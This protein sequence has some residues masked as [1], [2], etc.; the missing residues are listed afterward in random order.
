MKNIGSHSPQEAGG[1]EEK[2]E[3]EHI[4]RQHAHEL[5]VYHNKSEVATLMYIKA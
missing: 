4:G 1:L 2:Q 3:N 5:N